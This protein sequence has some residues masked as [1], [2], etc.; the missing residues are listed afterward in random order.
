MIEIKCDECGNTNI[1]GNYVY[2]EDCYNYLVKDNE[3]LRDEISRLEDELQKLEQQLE[4][5]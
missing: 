3:D 5:K 2:C 4:D 1:D